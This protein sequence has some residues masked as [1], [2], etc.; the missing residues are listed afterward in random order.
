MISIWLAALRQFSSN[1]TPWQGTCP[2]PGQRTP[3]EIRL[4]RSS[5]NYYNGSSFSA[6]TSTSYIDASF[7]GNQFAIDPT[8]TQQVFGNISADTN[9]PSASSAF[10]TGTSYASTAW[11][12]SSANTTIPATGSNIYFET[13]SGFVPAT[14]EVISRYA[15]SYTLQAMDLSSNWID[16]NHYNNLK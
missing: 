5:D 12:A 14:L 9:T 6:A 4:T 3:M 8:E 13:T 1:N 16:W 7:T 15:T 11:T 2:V 10:D